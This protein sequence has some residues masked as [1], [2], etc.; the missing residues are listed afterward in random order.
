MSAKTLL[1]AWGSVVLVALVSGELLTRHK[2]FWGP[3]VGVASVAE[4]A[5]LRAAES[6][7]MPTVPASNPH[8]DTAAVAVSEVVLDMQGR[9][10]DVRVLQSPDSAISIEVQQ[11]LRRWRFDTSKLVGP[12]NPTEI[13]GKVTFYFSL[14]SP[15]T[16]LT[17]DEVHNQ[18]KRPFW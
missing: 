4:G 12:T 1:S 18:L 15:G 5:L 17:S 3:K 11:A 14:V 2:Q 13:R 6:R 8:A 10:T 9:V 16:V 7:I